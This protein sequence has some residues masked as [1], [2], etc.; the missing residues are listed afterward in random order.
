MSIL[1]T[2][3][4]GTDDTIKMECVRSGSGFMKCGRYPTGCQ[5]AVWLPMMYETWLRAMS[6]QT[7][8]GMISA[9]LNRM[10]RD[11]VY[12]DLKVENSIL[13]PAYPEMYKDDRITKTELH[14]HSNIQEGLAVKLDKHFQ[15]IKLYS[16]YNHVDA[17]KLDGE[18]KH[19]CILA[20]LAESIDISGLGKVETLEIYSVNCK[21]IYTNDMQIGDIFLKVYQNSYKDWKNCMLRFRCEV[22]LPE[23]KHEYNT[24]DYNQLVFPPSKIQLEDLGNIMF[25]M[26]MY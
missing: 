17:S 19:V 12:P 18:R 10:P 23:T 20:P 7:F 3:I 15:H 9:G 11:F 1:D 21:K 16:A 6:D 24:K 13:C 4:A 25:E 22:E 2:T 5:D 26:G 8:G 14:I